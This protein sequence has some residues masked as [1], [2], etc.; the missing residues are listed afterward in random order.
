MGGAESPV[1]RIPEPAA[2]EMPDLNP[3]S[4]LL[5]LAS[6]KE[7]ENLEVQGSPHCSSDGAAEEG[8]GC[9]PGGWGGVLPGK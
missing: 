3:G 5:V 8:R 4:P 9:V 6:C 7:I 2:V 1:L